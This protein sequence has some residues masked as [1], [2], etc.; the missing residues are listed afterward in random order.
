LGVTPVEGGVNVAVA[1]AHASRIYFCHF[2][3]HGKRELHRIALTQRDGHVH[4]GFIAG[5]KPGA[6]YG[7]RADGPWN[8][9]DGQRFD[10]HKLLVDP[11]ATQL[12]RAYEF[13]P[14]LCEH[15]RETKDLVPKAIVMAASPLVQRQAPHPP[16]WI[17]EIP[18]KAFSIRHP[19]IS[20]D[21]RG[22]ISALAEPAALSHLKRL[23]VDTIEL[24]PLMAWIDERHLHALG[25]ANAWG[26]NPVTFMAPDPRLAPGGFAEIATT[27]ATLHNNGIQVLLDVVLNHTGESDAAGPTLSFR[28]LD[29]ST[30]YRHIHNA[31]VNDTGCGNTVALDHPLVMNYAIAALRHWVEATGIDGFRFDLAT[32]IGRDDHGFQ[33]DAPLLRAISADPVLSQ[34]ILIAEPW[35][36]G[37]GGYQLG[38][39]PPSWLEWNDRFRDD[40]RRFW[41]G[42]DFSANN[43]ATRLAGSSDVFA[44]KSPAASI[45]FISAHDGFTLADLTRYAHKHNMANG[46]GNRD[47]KSDEVTWV[48]GD[49]RALLAT[50]FLSRGTPMLTAGDEFGRSQNGNNNAYAQDNET[51]WLDWQGADINLLHYTAALVKLRDAHPLLSE[52]RFLSGADA[53]W[54]DEAGR[55]LDWSRPDNRFVV[56]SIKA[57]SEQ[58]AIVVNGSPVSQPMPLQGK[59]RRA[60]CSTEDVDCPPHSVALFWLETKRK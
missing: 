44:A 30:F 31:P 10:V 29:N 4:Y 60:F 34:T 51:T 2:D 14:G 21:R 3:A 15:G 35:D 56:L 37:P 58:L 45:N 20:P 57:H 25:L 43:L 53:Q 27:V 22:T 5:I 50:L 52:D 54:C 49:V 42:D 48:D 16:R 18:V 26:Y 24:M 13:H 6:L 7:L 32:I 28:G 59:W 47:G 17:Y 39:F 38:N 55:P 46:E 9:H 12:D 41:R 1:S 8:P 33:P 36:V 23:G 40:V 19:G 11:F